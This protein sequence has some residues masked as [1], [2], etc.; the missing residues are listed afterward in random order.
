MQRYAL[1]HLLGEPRV[2]WSMR[3][4]EIIGASGQCRTLVGKSPFPR[5]PSYARCHGL[6]L[7]HRFLSMG[8]W[9]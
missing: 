9:L 2:K 4:C 1:R 6:P 5:S 3:D 7:C 8:R